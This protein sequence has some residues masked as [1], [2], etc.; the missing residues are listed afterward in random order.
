MD[1]SCLINHE[2]NINLCKINSANN[3]ASSFLICVAMTLTNTGEWYFCGGYWSSSIPFQIPNQTR[4]T[5]TKVGHRRGKKR[6][7][8]TVTRDCD[9]N[10]HVWQELSNTVTKALH[11]SLYCS[12]SNTAFNKI[13]RESYSLHYSFS[14]H[15]L[16]TPSI[17]CQ[18]SILIFA[19]PFKVEL[20]IFS[21][22]L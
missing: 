20:T 8:E 14:E 3:N 18:V 11:H 12:T 1:W 15:I 7:Q 10:Y 2:L 13:L 19:P 17:H 6:W 4:S 16:L 9:K 22:H 5:V 21:Y